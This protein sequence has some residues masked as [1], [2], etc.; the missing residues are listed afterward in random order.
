M[1]EG[2]IRWKSQ[3]AHI[4]RQMF[5]QPVFLIPIFTQL[6]I[7]SKYSKIIIRHKISSS[8]LMVIR[9]CSDFVWLPI[10]LFVVLL[11]TWRTIAREHGGKATDKRM[12]SVRKPYC[13]HLFVKLRLMNDWGPISAVRS[14]TNGILKGQ[15]LQ[16]ETSP[17]S[18]RN[19]TFCN[20]KYNA[21]KINRLW[22]CSVWLFVSHSLGFFS[23]PS[24]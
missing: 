4:V 24:L 9:T 16:P 10:S 12:K 11:K 13:H 5:L 19:L 15:L 21:L 18:T 14:M 17:F 6:Q 22:R 23:I 8:I 1:C 2:L 7:Y 3:A 20:G